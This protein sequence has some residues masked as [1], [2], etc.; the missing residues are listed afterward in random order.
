MGRINIKELLA[1]ANINKK[2]SFQVSYGWKIPRE[3]I[4]KIGSYAPIRTTLTALIE[5]D[6]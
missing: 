3:S 6:E 2:H 1:K 5:Y 4:L